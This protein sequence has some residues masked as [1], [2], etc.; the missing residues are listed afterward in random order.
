MNRVRGIVAAIGRRNHLA[1]SR[2]YELASSDGMQPAVPAEQGHLDACARC[3]GLLVGY[4]RTEAVLSGA[5]IDRP[6]RSRS[7][8]STRIEAV[9]GVRVGRLGVVGP[10]RSLKSRR[11]AASLGVATI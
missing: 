11:W 1:D 2:L 3:R 4:R 9:G 6:V 5:W 7:E 8:A 10:A